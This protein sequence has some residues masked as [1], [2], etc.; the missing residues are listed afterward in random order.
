[1]I[2]LRAGT[3]VRVTIRNRLERTV[4]VRGLLDRPSVTSTNG[5]PGQPGALPAFAFADSLVIG[6]GE[7][8]EIT[9][10]P[11]APVTSFYYGRLVPGEGDYGRIVPPREFF[12]SFSLPG[13]AADEGAFMGALI[14]D[15]ETGPAPA[16][17]RVFMITRWGH[18]DEPGSSDPWKMFLNGRSW[19]FTE[20]LAYTVGDSVRWRLINASFVHHPMHLHGF[21]FRVDARGDTQHDVALPPEVRPWVVTEDMPA[22]SAVRITWV[23][24]RPG[25]WLFHCHL[26]RH[27]G[28]LQR[29]AA[30]G[31]AVPLGH[32]EGARHSMAGLVTGITVRA[33]GA[34][35][36]E[37]APSTRLDLWTGQR[38]SVFGAEPELGFVLQE[39]S[40]PPPT[41][42]I[43]VPGSTLVLRRDE[44]TRIVVHNRLDMPVAVHWHGLELR[45]LYDGVGHWSGV[46]GA[47]RAPI[48]PGDSQSVLITPP[49]AGTF[50][51]HTHGEAGHELSQGLYGAFLVLES[52][53]PWD[54]EID[55]VFVLA[56]RG[57]K[58]DPPPAVNGRTDPQPQRFREGM[59]YRLRFIHISPDASKRVRLVK[60]ARPVTWTPLAKDGADLPE[61][62]RSPVEADFDIG[63]GEAFDF[64]WMPESAGDYA[65]VVDTQFFPGNP[66][67]AQQ[68]VRFVVSR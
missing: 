47:T 48:A 24:E 2:R 26:I 50:F 51:Y 67:S 39:G 55:R 35:P 66:G 41:D 5:P 27:M 12:P 34:R 44:P 42:S 58:L 53:Q 13:G 8:R 60:D 43:I 36:A 68:R 37:P 54:P 25:N 6:P 63:V 30:D 15:P 3:P 33:S 52:D 28:P 40:T 4:L 46:P 17:E 9:F 16:D 7:V 10:T 31:E 61:S 20:R 19:P 56:A 23:P 22:F 11:T 49:R 59:R 57:A 29:F 21:F 18:P 1:M 32:D 14:V 65:L 62:L 45:S 64:A 38:D